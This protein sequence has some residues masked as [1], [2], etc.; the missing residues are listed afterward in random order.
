MPLFPSSSITPFA[1]FPARLSILST[2][3]PILLHEALLPLFL[4]FGTLLLYPYK[5]HLRNAIALPI[6]LALYIR[7]SILYS[8]SH[9]GIAFCVGAYT[10]FG[11]L[12]AFNLL[13]VKDV[14]RDA[15]VKWVIDDTGIPQ[16]SVS[17][18]SLSS[19]GVAGANH[20][21]GNANG[22]TVPIGQRH[23]NGSTNGDA[24]RPSTNGTASHL[25]NGATNGYAN[26]K[27]NGATSNGDIDV[28][29]S[30]SDGLGYPNLLTYPLR[31]RIRFTASLI[32]SSRG[33]GWKFQ[34]RQIPSPQPASTTYFSFLRTHLSNILIAYIILDFFGYIVVTDPYF[35]TSNCWTSA[36]HKSPLSSQDWQ[37][38]CQPPYISSSPVAGIIYHHIFRK[39][40]TLL[41]VYAILSQLYSIAAIVF[42]LPLPYPLTRP[43][44]WAPLFGSLTAGTSLRGFW[45]SFWHSIFKKGFS[46]PGEWLC[47]RVLG[48]DRKS[49]VAQVILV[50]TAFL[51][52]GVLHGILGRSGSIKG[53]QGDKCG[54]QEPY[55]EDGDNN[56]D[57]VLVVVDL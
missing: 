31:H 6:I 26:G 20:G 9:W 16:G 21:N 34:V 43:Y 11:S 3:T 56:L 22:T 25:G 45:T 29:A 17:K 1:H 51:N 4:L 40:L 24:T 38:E 5:S 18:P 36:F 50:I 39:H 37:Q 47:S 42:T 57:D 14:G 10:Y 2:R 12:Q 48:L 23:S 15:D 41:S 19:D 52:S 13:V 32:S 8:S 44:S 35:Y 33:V 53:A 46:Y 49:F 55:G 27:L 7:L 28:K 30:T 54:P